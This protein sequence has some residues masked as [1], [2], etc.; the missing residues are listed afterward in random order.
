MAEIV[1]KSQR[2]SV[3]AKAHARLKKVALKRKWSVAATAEKVLSAGF[4]ALHW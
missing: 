1:E 3:S 2:V 4:R